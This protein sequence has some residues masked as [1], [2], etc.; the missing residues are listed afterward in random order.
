[1][2]KRFYLQQKEQLTS[3][4]VSAQAG[5]W[6]HIPLI[7]HTQWFERHSAVLTREE[8]CLW[9]YLCQFRLGTKFSTSEKTPEGFQE[10]TRVYCQTSLSSRTSRGQDDVTQQSAL[11]VSQRHRGHCGT[12]GKVCYTSPSLSRAWTC[13]SVHLGQH[14]HWTCLL[15]CLSVCL[16][17][18][19]QYISHLAPSITQLHY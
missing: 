3:V 4:H 5:V 9:K 13:G 17:A 15:V 2:S 7:A 10:R 14:K 16:P 19:L 8:P 11:N 1:M 18:S 6:E 12:T